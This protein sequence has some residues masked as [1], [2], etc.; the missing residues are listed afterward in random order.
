MLPQK[1]AKSSPYLQP[2][3]NYSFFL[4]MNFGDCVSFGL[5]DSA[6]VEIFDHQQRMEIRN[7]QID[8]T[9]DLR[10]LVNS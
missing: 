1:A 8:F 10:T 7:S 9:A 5:I 4:K 6:L 3:I 2:V